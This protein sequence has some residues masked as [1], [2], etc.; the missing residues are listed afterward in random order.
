MVLVWNRIGFQL[1]LYR[2]EWICHGF[3]IDWNCFFNGFCIGLN[4]FLMVLVWIQLNINGRDCSADALGDGE[5]TTQ[6]S[7]DSGADSHGDL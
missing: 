4:C 5:F 2:F 7:S 3:G 6:I 1:F